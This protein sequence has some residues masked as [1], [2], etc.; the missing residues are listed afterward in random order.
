MYKQTRWRLDDLYPG[1]DSPEFQGAL[2]QIEE[3]LQGLEDHHP[4]LTSKLTGDEFLEII[5]RYED[6]VRLLSRVINYGF[7]LLAEDIRSGRAQECWGQVQHIAAQAE[8][9]TLFLNLWWNSL[10]DKKAGEFLK[11]ATDYKY[12]LRTMR[13]QKPFSLSEIEEKI[14][15]IKDAAGAK[16]LLKLYETITGRYLFKLK[17]EGEI[18]YFTRHELNEYVRDPNPDVRKKA[19][20]EYFRVFERD[21]PILGQIYQSRVRDWRSENVMLRGHDSPIAVRNLIN[22]LTDDT[23]EV[24]LEACRDNISLFH[25]Y[26]QLKTHALGIGSLRRYDIYAPAARQ[27]RRYPYEEA[28]N[29]VLESFHQFDPLLADYARSVLEDRHLD[30]EVREGKR[31]GAFCVAVEPSLTPWV[32][33]SYEGDVEDMATLA[34]ELGRAVHYILAA[35]HTAFTQKPSRMLSEVAASFCELLAIDK[36][37]AVDDDKETRRDLLYKRMDNAYAAIMRQA[38]FVMF[39]QKAHDQI[40]DGASVDDLNEMYLASLKDQ[41]SASI[42]LSDDFRYEWLGI[43]T[44][45]HLPF[46]AYAYVFGRLIVL[47]LYHQYRMEGDPFKSRFLTLL[48]AGGSDSP[49]RIVSQV[50]IDITS[51]EA[52]QA[53]FD[54]LASDL[55]ELEVLEGLRGQE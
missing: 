48:A 47:S 50:G 14:V 38:G 46:Y 33:M 27:E 11:A 51:Q 19:Y 55:E 23:V 42:E 31:Q 44:L 43:S 24:L 49:A 15:T 35:H 13:L 45:F 16:G 30:S 1:P 5:R 2:G 7:L 3:K 54:A 29:L 52:W 40:D 36:L 10:D 21:A 9:R 18:R 32:S 41:F 17:I 28:A 4:W 34:R 39:E 25:R 53:G 37:M 20:Q 8:R 26:F 22:D 12:W 6:L